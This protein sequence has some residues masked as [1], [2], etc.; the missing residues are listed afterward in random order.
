M[1]KDLQEKTFKLNLEQNPERSI[2]MKKRELE[3][4]NHGVGTRILENQMFDSEGNILMTNTC[5]GGVA[6]NQSTLQLNNMLLNN[7]GL[8]NSIFKS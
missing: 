6:T 5:S 8:L 7:Y 1:I 2:I 3:S 4:S